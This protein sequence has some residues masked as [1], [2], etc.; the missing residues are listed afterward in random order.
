MDPDER[1]D[2]ILAAQFE[3]DRARL[4][5]VA[6]RMLG[7][8]AD[9]DDAVQEA[10]LRFSRAG[11]DGVDNLGG[12]LTTIVARVCLDMLRSRSSRREEALDA[13]PAPGP[14]LGSHA[15]DPA[16][17]ALV[18]DAVGLALLVVLDSLAPAERLAFVLH[19]LFAMP[20]DQIAPIVD[21]SLA[22][23]RQL[24]S[25]AR[26]R[27]QGRDVVGHIDQARQRQVVDAFL[28]A[29]RLGD[30]D[31]L[32][33]VLDP[34][35]VLRADA[36]LLPVGVTSEARGAKVVA[37]RARTFSAAAVAEDVHVALVDG[38]VGLVT[39]PGGIVRVV[40]APTI[41]GDRIVDIDVIAEPERL[42]RLELVWLD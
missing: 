38:A 16:E 30:F 5:A 29:S 39:A 11:T 3:Q 19:D 25:R 18:A 20:F 40:F 36:M 4:R 34:D 24:A 13:A 22:A 1:P 9:A 32:L 31:A 33:R 26:R 23:T 14:R 15:G 41:V 17:E 2:E 37:G 35:V 21:R 6:V 12:W 8:G 42:A 10:W 28:A 27:V 7:S